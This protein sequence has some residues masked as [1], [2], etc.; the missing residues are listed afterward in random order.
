MVILQ[1][2]TFLKPSGMF[3]NSSE[4]ASHQENA[5]LSQATEQAP[6]AEEYRS[7]TMS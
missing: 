5:L 1:G 6:L 2:F 3:L 7:A 4:N